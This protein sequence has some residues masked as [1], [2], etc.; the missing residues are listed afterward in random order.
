MNTTIADKIR[1]AQKPAQTAPTTPQIPPKPP[2]LAPQTTGNGSKYSQ[3]DISAFERKDND[4]KLLG[5][6]KAASE[7]MR[8]Y[9]EI[10]AANGTFTGLKDAEIK[11]YLVAAFTA[12]FESCKRKLYVKEPEVKVG[13]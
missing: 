11:A 8:A 1:Q 10:G 2:V 4:M 12:Q 13:E 3:Q 5:A 7:F 6:M 9:A